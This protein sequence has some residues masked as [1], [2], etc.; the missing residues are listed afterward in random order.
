MIEFS[1]LLA[2]WKIILEKM[3]GDVVMSKVD[4]P[5]NFVLNKAEKHVPNGKLVG[6]TNCI[7]L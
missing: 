3:T 6:T 2:S 5:T 7:M 4:A 1:E